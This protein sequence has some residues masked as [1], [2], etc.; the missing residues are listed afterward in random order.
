M[1]GLLSKGPTLSSFYYILGKAATI[2]I[3]QEILCLPYAGF[4]LNTLTF[5]RLYNNTNL[6]HLTKLKMHWSHLSI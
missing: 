2:R 1:E 3:G 6:G 4:F 5:S